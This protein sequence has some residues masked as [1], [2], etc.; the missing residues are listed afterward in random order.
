MLVLAPAVEGMMLR[1]NI[2]YA[3]MMLIDRED[4]SSKWIK[5]T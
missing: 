1:R 5:D 3:D 4:Q 2:D